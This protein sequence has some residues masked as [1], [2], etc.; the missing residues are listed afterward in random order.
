MNQWGTEWALLGPAIATVVSTY[1][2][3]I[4][5]VLLI[6]RHLH[7]RLLEL[8]PWSQLLRTTVLSACAAV[9]S[10][11]LSQMVEQTVARLLIGVLSFVV[12]ILAV[13]WLHAGQ[14]EEIRSLM[15]SFRKP[16]EFER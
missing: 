10:L 2:Q 14:R 3:V 11:I 12:V 7:W 15:V 13:S 4:V 5:L 8:M 16:R 1:V 9:V 6:A